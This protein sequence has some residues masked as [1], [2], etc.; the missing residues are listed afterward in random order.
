MSVLDEE[1]EC[2]RKILARIGRGVIGY[3]L[4]KQTSIKELELPLLAATSPF[5]CLVLWVTFQMATPCLV[6]GGRAIAIRFTKRT[7]KPLLLEEA[8]VNVIPRMRIL[9]PYC[10]AQGHAGFVGLMRQVARQ[11]NDAR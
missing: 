9:M 7:A 6:G 3:E 5:A 10:V 2:L 8:R 1:H 11:V 4:L